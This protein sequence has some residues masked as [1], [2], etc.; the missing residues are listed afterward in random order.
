MAKDEAYKRLIQDK[1]WRKMR[2][3]KLSE[4]PLCERCTK[5]GRVRAATEVHHVVPIES[6]ISEAEKTRLAYD[7]NNLQSL[8]RECHTKT[9]TEMGSRNRDFLKKRKAQQLVDFEDKFLK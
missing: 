6:A 9:H 3:Q 8:C 4:T 7:F 1:R 2:R 5:E